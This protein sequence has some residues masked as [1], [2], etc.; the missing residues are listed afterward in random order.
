MI[1]IISNKNYVTKFID[2]Y[3]NLDIRTKKKV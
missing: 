1:I 2:I 3:Y